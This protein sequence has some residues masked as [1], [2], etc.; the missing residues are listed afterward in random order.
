MKIIK[1]GFLLFF[2]LLLVLVA[3]AWTPDTQFQ[4]M[5][6]KYTNE[7]SQFIE[8]NDQDRLHYREQGQRDGD[9]VILIHGTGASLH[10]WEPLIANLK[11]HFRLVSLDLPGH[12]LSGKRSDRDYSMPVLVEAVK[13]VMD[14]LDINSAT[15][16]G[17][18]LGGAVAWEASLTLDNRVKSL[19]LIA[20]SGAPRKVKSQSNIGFKLLGSFIGPFIVETFTPRFIIKSSLEQTV[21]DSDLISSE[22]VDRYWEL[23]RLAGNRQ[24]ML[25]LSRSPKREQAWRVLKNISKHTLIIWGDSDPLLPVEMAETFSNEIPKN[26]LVVLKNVGHLPMEE[27]INDVY[28]AILDFLMPI[29]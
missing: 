27:A 16:V 29:R 15:L 18:S 3:L 24:A 22:M 21:F 14:E 8:L 28:D 7:Y 25:D 4:D 1:L 2:L 23:L 20:P 12:G 13:L 11:N 26:K 10:T 17:N 5:K 9:A 6:Q 19:I